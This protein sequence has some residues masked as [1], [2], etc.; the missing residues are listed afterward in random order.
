MQARIALE[1]QRF[2]E[3]AAAA[4]QREKEWRAFADALTAEHRALLAQEASLNQQLQSSRQASGGATLDSLAEDAATA[5][6]SWSSVLQY[7]SLAEALSSSAAD[8]FVHGRPHRF[9]VDGA[10]LQQALQEDDTGSPAD[11][12]SPLADGP[13]LALP[14]GRAAT[15]ADGQSQIEPEAGSTR[16]H[17]GGVASTRHPHASGTGGAGADSWQSAVHGWPSMMRGLR[18]THRGAAAERSNGSRM[19]PEEG[20]GVDFAWTRRGGSAAGEG[21]S[22]PAGGGV[23]GAGSG[24]GSAPPLGQGEGGVDVATV[25]R[26]FSRTLRKVQA[27]VADVAT[28]GRSG[29]EHLLREPEVGEAD[30]AHVAALQPI[31]REQQQHLANLEAKVAAMQDLLPR[32]LQAL[33]ALR[34]DVEAA[35]AGLHVPASLD[36]EPEEAAAPWEGPSSSESPVATKALA[37]RLLPP[38]PAVRPP[39]GESWQRGQ[40]AV[41]DLMR[42]LQE[43]GGDG[44]YAVS[45]RGQAVVAFEPSLLLSTDSTD[46]EAVAALRLAIH[47]AAREGSEAEERAEARRAPSGDAQQQGLALRTPATGI[48]ATN[49]SPPIDKQQGEPAGGT[50]SAEG[51]AGSEGARSRAAGSAAGGAK[52]THASP[53]KGLPTRNASV[54]V[55]NGWP[56][57]SVGSKPWPHGGEDAGPARREAPPT[58]RARARS[59]R[60][61]G[62]EDSDRHGRAEPLLP[63]REASPSSGGYSSDGEPLSDDGRGGSAPRASNGQAH[64]NGGGSR[65]SL[66]GVKL[67]RRDG[68]VP[69]HRGDRETSPLLELGDLAGFDE[70]FD[71]LAPLSVEETSLL[72]P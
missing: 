6:R 34:R 68:G 30:N 16:V 24:Q 11:P 3:A 31:L 38:T 4:A 60:L 52:L 22:G 43:M 18:E 14:A 21:P 67:Y 61:P 62:A 33:E 64:E 2:L 53:A 69:Q 5:S 19:A 25:L 54:G 48:W 37:L 41:G 15:R 36:Q 20:P 7:T 32:E 58:S 17:E 42:V 65:G 1:R 46:D 13:S 29:T 9:R 49:G 39:K 59:S 44:E 57:G 28:A 26:R 23:R 10:A 40:V 56:A 35:T 50:P 51:A 71:L 70:D 27:R 66:L 45:P 55:P 63:D 72:S 12:N 47:S 8:D